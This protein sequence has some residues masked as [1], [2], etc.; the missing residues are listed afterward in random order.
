MMS[1]DDQPIEIYAPPVYMPG[2]KVRSR[3]TIRNDGTMWGVEI[4]EIVVRKGDVGYVRDIGTYLQQF[5]IYAVDFIDRGTV[6]GMRAR[7]LTEPEGVQ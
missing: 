2:D 3:L 6:V 4:G 5:Y 1:P 7:E